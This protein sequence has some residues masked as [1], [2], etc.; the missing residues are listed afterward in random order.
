MRNRSAELPEETCEALLIAAADDLG[1]LDVIG[2]A[3]SLAALS[4]A[5]DAGLVRIVEARLEFRHPLVR[6]AIYQRASPTERR[7]AHAALASALP[8]EQRSRRVWH[9]GASLVEPDERVAGALEDVAREAQERRGPAAAAAAWRRA[10][11][12]TPDVGLRARRLLAASEA[13]WE[14]GASDAAQQAADAAL[15]ACS[16]PLLHADIVRMR[17]RIAAQSIASQSGGAA[18]EVAETLREEA[19]AVAP[20]DSTRAAYLLA[21]AVAVFWPGWDVAPN[22]ELARAAREAAGDSDDPRFDYVLG[23]E[24]G[25]QGAMDESARLLEAVELAILDD[26][27][28]RDNPRELCLAADCAWWRN[29]PRRTCALLARAV[30][31]ARELGL[32][33]VVA[34]ELT[35]LGGYQIDVGAWDEADVG[36]AEAIRLGEDTGQ[37]T[38]VGTALSRRA[39]IAARRGAEELFEE[40]N[41]VASRYAGTAAP[42]RAF[43]RNSRCLLALGMGRPEVAIASRESTESYSIEQLSANA[44]DLIEAYI[45]SGRT[46]EAVARLDEVA[47][48]VHL[49]APR[50]AYTRCRALMAGHDQYDALFHESLQLFIGTGDVFEEARTRLCL[51]ERL[52]RASRR[53]DARRELAAALDTFEHLRAASWADRARRE[54][55]AS[56]QHRRPGSPEARDDVTPQ[57]RQIATSLRKAEPT[58]R[59]VRCSSSVRAPSR[60]TWDACFES[61]DQR[62][63]RASDE[64]IARRLSEGPRRTDLGGGA[65]VDRVPEP[66]W[67]WRRLGLELAQPVERLRGQLR[68]ALAWTLLGALERAAPGVDALRKLGHGAAGGGK[69]LGGGIERVLRR[70]PVGL[71]AR[72]GP[73]ALPA[74]RPRP[75]PAASPRPRPAAAERAFGFAALRRGLRRGAPRGGCP[76]GARPGS[77]C[78]RGIRRRAAH[79]P[80]CRGAPLRPGRRRAPRRAGSRAPDRASLPSRDSRRSSRSGASRPAGPHP[81]LQPPHV[82]R[83]PIR[84]RAAPRATAPRRRGARPPGRAPPGPPGLPSRRRRSASAASRPLPLRRASLAP[85]LPGGG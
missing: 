57:E 3:T 49:D 6:S 72:Q 24:L 10:A 63:K 71:R 7:A 84:R 42:I 17:E 20:L 31:R 9:R 62:P 50:A 39:E 82:G 75:A 4:P 64:G 56:G 38:I 68:A 43:E 30:D 21:D 13:S 59:S 55:V 81:D 61:L 23:L 58:G 36:L 16:D 46:D 65:L 44:L 78:R 1:R 77:R 85:E 66:G 79:A 41:L 29:N 70:A 51:G 14:A 80:A 60:R 12:L 2:R 33:G 34:E 67:F 15:A 25:R 52:R 69:L 48:H 11:E 47:T 8:Q 54:L 5:E 22:V 76:A 27:A 73:P 35:D 53:R 74:L 32:A 26:P 40:L 28:R 19:Q 83:R 18:R 37:L 45:R